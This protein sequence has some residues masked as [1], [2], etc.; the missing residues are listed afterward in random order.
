MWM[1]LRPCPLVYGAGDGTHP[2]G[3]VAKFSEVQTCFWSIALTREYLLRV[4]VPAGLFTH[5]AGKNW[6]PAAWSFQN[7]DGLSSRDSQIGQE[8]LESLH[9]PLLGPQLD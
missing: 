8:G 4:L 6:S 1:G 5:H 9:G 2:N 7:L 3:V